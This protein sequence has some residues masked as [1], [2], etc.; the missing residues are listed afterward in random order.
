MFT[1][2]RSLLGRLA[3]GAEVAEPESPCALQIAAYSPAALGI[4]AKNPAALGIAAYNPGPLD[5]DAGLC[6][7]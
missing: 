6:E 7:L 5:L 4:A 3:G 2:I 1:L